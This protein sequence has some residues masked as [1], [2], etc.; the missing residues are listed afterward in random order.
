MFIKIKNQSSI[1]FGFF[2]LR[3]NTLFFA[4]HRV[5]QSKTLRTAPLARTILGRDSKKAHTRLGMCFFGE[6]DD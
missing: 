3:E 1:D 5:L 4:Q 2:V 6:V